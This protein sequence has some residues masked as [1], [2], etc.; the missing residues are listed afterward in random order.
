MVGHVYYQWNVQNRY[1]LCNITTRVAYLP[2]SILRGELVLPEDGIV[3]TEGL[4]TVVVV[5]VVVP[6]GQG[7]SQIFGVAD[8]SLLVQKEFITSAHIS[9]L[10]LCN[11]RTGCI[12]VQWCEELEL[13]VCHVS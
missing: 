6:P 5:V 8:T 13:T 3:G 11:F 2:T 1:D 10:F 9:R 12:C 4:V 7:L